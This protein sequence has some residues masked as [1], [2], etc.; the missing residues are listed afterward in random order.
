MLRYLAFLPLLFISATAPADSNPGSQP[1]NAPFV[2]QLKRQ[3]AKRPGNL[4]YSPSSISIALA[5]VREGAQGQ[6]AAEIDR[7]LGTKNG[8]DAK[9]FVRSFKTPARE[10]GG[11][12]PPE[13]AVAN[14][15]FADA[16]TSFEQPFLDVTSKAYLA[17]ALW[18]RYSMA[19][20]RVPNGLAG[21]DAR[22]G[23][24]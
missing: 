17:P 10:P 3:L 16:A 13:L 6:T 14:R 8:S 12:M 4:V 19:P 24:L 23:S 5:M 11:R 18:S 1:P 20:V 2:A 9:A 15:I 7:V 21:M 22:R